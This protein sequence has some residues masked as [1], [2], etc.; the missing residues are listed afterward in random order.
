M[1]VN[2]LVYCLT[3]IGLFLFFSPADVQAQTISRQ[4]IGFAGGTSTASNGIT[5]HWTAGETFTQHIQSSDQKN[6][7]T[8]GFQQPE[9]TPQNLFASQTTLVK[10]APNPVKTL[11]NINVLSKNQE[12]LRF[13][14]TDVQG[15][16]LINREKLVDHNF[17]LDL[18]WYAQG[19]YFLH[20][21]H[22]GK[23]AVQTEKIVKVK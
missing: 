20:I 12:D 19:I 22:Q 18:E 14:L 6:R 21:Y 23:L 10:V 8:E 9:I 17:E 1:K 11:L 13:S 2:S 16:L 7:I 3:A 15:Q 4:V 5:M